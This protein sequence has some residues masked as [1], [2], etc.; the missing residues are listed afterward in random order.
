MRVRLLSRQ[1]NSVAKVLHGMK[2]RHHLL[3]KR[4]NQQLMRVS[5]RLTD[6]EQPSTSDKIVRRFVRGLLREK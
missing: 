1:S 5:E 6:E 2:R 4:L 3:K